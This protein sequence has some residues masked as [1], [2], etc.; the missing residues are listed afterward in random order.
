MQ[1]HSKS[2]DKITV[3]LTLYELFITTM[4]QVLSIILYKH[5]SWGD[6]VKNFQNLMTFWLTNEYLFFWPSKDLLSEE[7]THTIKSLI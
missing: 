2:I 3:Q 6:F 4:G 7:F 1:S 5:F